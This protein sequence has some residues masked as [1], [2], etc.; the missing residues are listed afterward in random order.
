M[1]ETGKKRSVKE[2][3]W[4]RNTIHRNEEDEWAGTMDE[5]ESTNR[6]RVKSISLIVM[7]IKEG[8]MNGLKDEW[9]TLLHRERKM[10]VVA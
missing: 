10:A 6:L 2:S 3:A 8:R 5:W 7:R 4:L 9:K 1:G